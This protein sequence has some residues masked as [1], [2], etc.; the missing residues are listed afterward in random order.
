M[1]IPGFSCGMVHKLILLHMFVCREC[2]VEGEGKERKAKVAKGIGAEMSWMKD[3]R[4]LWNEWR[5][6][7]EFYS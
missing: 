4:W 7:R 3:T 6:V 1:R 2:I 5:E